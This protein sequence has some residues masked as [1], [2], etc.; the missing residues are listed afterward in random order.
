QLTLFAHRDRGARSPGVRHGVAA[1]RDPEER[2]ELHAEPLAA[3]AERRLHVRD[4]RALGTGRQLAER[5]DA[6]CLAR[7]HLLG[8]LALGDVAADRGVAERR[9]RLRIAD[10]EET[11]HEGKRAT[12][13]EMPGAE[14]PLDVPDPERRRRELSQRGDVLGHD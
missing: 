1:S 10:E 14:L 2:P 9:A 11:E 5:A 6:P 4:A 13:P 7:D 12:G 8:L 3:E